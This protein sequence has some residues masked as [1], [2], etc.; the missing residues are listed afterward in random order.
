MK[1]DCKICKLKSPAAELL[2]PDEMD[3]LE[4]NCA[5]VKFSKGE[6]IFPGGNL[7]DQYRLLTVGA[8]KNSY[9]KPYWR[10]NTKVK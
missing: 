8:R 3:T 7:R 5:Q 1:P 9:E 10:K 6:T 2:M 4:Q